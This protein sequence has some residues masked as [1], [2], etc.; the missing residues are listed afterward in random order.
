MR[1]LN[2]FFTVLFTAFAALQYNDPDPYI[3]IPIYLYAA[4][5][6]YLASRGLYKRALFIAGLMAYLLYGLY[7]FFD[8]NGVMSWA[9]EHGAESLVTSMKAEKPW[10]EQTREFGGLL[11]LGL[12]MGINLYHSRGLMRK[13]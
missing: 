4:W 8:R 3:W 7:L 5:L 13:G 2:L 12:A 6:C 9:T 10:I 1:K 11:I